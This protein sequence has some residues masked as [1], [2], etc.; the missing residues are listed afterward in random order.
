MDQLALSRFLQSLREYGVQFVVED[1]VLLAVGAPRDAVP[2]DML[3]TLREHREQITAY[4]TPRR[5]EVCGTTSGVG[6]GVKCSP[7][8]A[9]ATPPA[10]G[11]A[12]G[13]RR[14]AA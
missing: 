1:G 7:C 2:V 9:A 10:G 6:S 14:R 13:S 12:E 11:R 5:C 8:A 3:T 4:L